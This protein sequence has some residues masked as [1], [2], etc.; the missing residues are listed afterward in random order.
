MLAGQTGENFSIRE[1]NEK[2]VELKSFYQPVFD[3]FAKKYP[4][5]AGKWDADSGDDPEKWKQI[6]KSVAWN[7]G[8]AA[9]GEKIFRERGCQTCHTGW[10]SLGPNLTGVASRFSVEDLFDAIIYPSRD[11]APLYRSVAF[12]MRDGQTYTG[13][14][15]FE[16]ADGVIALTGPTT[17]V[18]LED[19]EIVSRQSTDQSLMPTGL[20]NG[21]KPEDLA[22][23]Y[24]YLRSLS[25]AQ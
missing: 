25:P 8:D 4:A 1:A 2:K 20:L 6:L 18:R 5:L 17:S 16:S 7:K 21:L 23:L 10:T 11:V 3:R 24:R 9:R 14:V 22:D 13:L 19:K 12:R 15:A